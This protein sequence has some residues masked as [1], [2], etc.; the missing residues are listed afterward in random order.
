MTLAQAPLLVTGATHSAQ[1]FR[2]MIRDLSRGSEGVT[3]YG[4]LK[5][6]PL[7][8]PGAGVQISDGSA[9]I[10]GRA[11]AWQGSYTAYNIGTATVPVAPTGAT[12]RTD[13]IVLRVLDPE[14]EGSKDP[15]KDAVNVF[16]V[17][18]NVEATATTPP[19]GMTGVALACIDIPA[20][21]A[22]ITAG[23]I[24]DL[25]AVAN[26]RTVSKL[27]TA[28]PAEDQPYKG[29]GYTWTQWPPVARWKVYV[30]SWAVRARIKM[31]LAGLQLM[32]GYGYGGS[33][34]RLGT[35]QYQSVVVESNAGSERLNFISADTID[36]PPAYR[37]TVQWLEHMVAR[38]S[39]FPGWFEADV[40]TTAIAEISFDEGAA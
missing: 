13:M 25:R 16:E 18:P 39:D 21:T 11:N 3:E 40:A 7:P 14:F 33:A 2:M 35:L 17:I 36:I 31:T 28:S 19:A 22:T 10:R 1:T 38:S 32:G 29:T 15:A 9:V 30:P 20:K 26:P 37:D 23:M 5:V 27:F 24:R 12:P 34:G 4:D 6:V 8:T